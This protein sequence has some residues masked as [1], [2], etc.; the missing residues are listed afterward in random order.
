[1]KI[2]IKK[3]KSNVINTRTRHRLAGRIDKC[4]PPGEE[5]AWPLE[6]VASVESVE[7][8]PDRR[9]RS[10]E[11]RLAVETHY[12]AVVSILSLYYRLDLTYLSIYI[13]LTI[14]YI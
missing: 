9:A 14:M 6:S 7:W 8:T 3:N 12:H 4:A 13:Y 11:I 5:T 10:L 2:I 1:M